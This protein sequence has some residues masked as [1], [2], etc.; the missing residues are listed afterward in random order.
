[1]VG[2][3]LFRGGDRGN[4]DRASWPGNHELMPEE[5]KELWLI[6]KSIMWLSQPAS[7]NEVLRSS[8]LTSRIK[9]RQNILRPTPAPAP[10]QSHHQV[11]VLH[12]QQGQLDTPICLPCF[13]HGCCCASRSRAPRANISP[14]TKLSRDPMPPS[15][16][17]LRQTQFQAWHQ[18]LGLHLHRPRRRAVLPLQCGH[19]SLEHPVYDISSGP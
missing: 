9:L 5:Y 2:Q 17:P 3:K 8:I 13:N 6:P 18:R 10:C 4:V 16:S 11:V 15:W 7:P 19:I 12:W 1:M 14:F